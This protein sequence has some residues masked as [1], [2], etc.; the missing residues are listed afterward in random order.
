MRWKTSGERDLTVEYHA[1]SRTTRSLARRCEAG[2]QSHF[3][4]ASRFLYVRNETIDLFEEADLG[5]VEGRVD[6]FSKHFG[7]VL[8]PTK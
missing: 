8:V 1:Y 7:I 2:R 5:T 3:G 6:S 4:A